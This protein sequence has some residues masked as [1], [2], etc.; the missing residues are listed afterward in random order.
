MSS[1]RLT[2]DGSVSETPTTPSISVFDCDG[3]ERK[4]DDD[5]SPGELLY[6]VHTQLTAGLHQLAIDGETRGHGLRTYLDNPPFDP[7]KKREHAEAED[8]G[9]DL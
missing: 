6:T 3:D 5:A 8:E 1:D 7:F 4:E 2:V 9:F